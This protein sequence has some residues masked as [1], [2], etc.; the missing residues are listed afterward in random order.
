MQL[1]IEGMGEIEVPI[2]GIG[3]CLRPAPAV[4]DDLLRQNQAA[5][6]QSAV[7]GADGVDRQRAFGTQLLQQPEVRP[8]IDRMGGERMG[9]AVPRQR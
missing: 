9:F 1:R 3:K 6:P 2:G 8:V 4:I 5:R 7:D